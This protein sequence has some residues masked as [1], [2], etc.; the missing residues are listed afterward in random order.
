MTDRQE[1][2]GAFAA[3]LTLAGKIDANQ[4]KV[5]MMHY[6]HGRADDAFHWQGFVDKQRERLNEMNR[7]FDSL[8]YGY[9][10]DEINEIKMEVIR[11]KFMV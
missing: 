10:S 9:L 7:T 6:M 1:I 4:Q 5:N 11:N 8:V 2:A 3:I